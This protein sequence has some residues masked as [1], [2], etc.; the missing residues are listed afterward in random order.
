M[1][2]IGMNDNAR[3]PRALLCWQVSVRGQS[4]M[5]ASHLLGGLL[6]MGDAARVGCCLGLAKRRVAFD[7]ISSAFV[8]ITV[9]LFHY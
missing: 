7:S 1:I 3:L 6:S 9:F 8:I 2:D 5:A 4:L